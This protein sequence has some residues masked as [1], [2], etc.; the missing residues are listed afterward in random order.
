VHDPIADAHEARHEYGV[1]LCGW[2]ALPAAAA[3]VLAVAHREFLARP[4]QD[5][6]ARLR[7]NGV[8]MDVKCALDPAALREQSVSVWRL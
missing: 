1:E 5:Y 7:P 3:I 4:P 6:L 2:D 8:L